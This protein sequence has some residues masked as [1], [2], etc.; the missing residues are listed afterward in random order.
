MLVIVRPHF[1]DLHRILLVTQQYHF[2]VSARDGVGA[3]HVAIVGT[4]SNAELAVA[5]ELWR[6]SGESIQSIQTV[7]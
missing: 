2:V 7:R 1:F 4:G 3:V 6:K 5:M